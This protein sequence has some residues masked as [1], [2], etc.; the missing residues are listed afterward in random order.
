[1]PRAGSTYIGD[2]V[3]ASYDGYQ[4]CLETGDRNNNVIYLEPEVMQNLVNYYKR[5]VNEQRQ[6]Q[7]DSS[8]A[9]VVEHPASQ[10]QDELQG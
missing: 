9:K 7:E 10:Q 6:S 3:Y 5:V 2:A 1:M 8:S 4:V